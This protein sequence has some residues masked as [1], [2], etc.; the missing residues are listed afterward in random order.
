M[1]IAGAGIRQSRCRQGCIAGQCCCGVARKTVVVVASFVSV[2]N[3]TEFQNWVV[4]DVVERDQPLRPNQSGH[5]L[6]AF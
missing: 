1:S 6:N 4:R 2:V 5:M 3:Q